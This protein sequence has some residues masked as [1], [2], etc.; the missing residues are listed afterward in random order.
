[1]VTIAEKGLHVSLG[2]RMLV[3][4]KVHGRSNEDWCLH[5][6]IGGDEHVVCNA[7]RHLAHGRCRT[8]CNDHRIRPET[9][10]HVRIPGTITLREELAHHRLVGQRRE[11]DRGNELLTGRRNDHLYLSS[12]LDET[13]DD[14]T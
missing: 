9:E 11:G 8:W 3:H 5:G 10:I 14:K 2:R 6:E 13:T 12:L 1:M 7:M 4:I